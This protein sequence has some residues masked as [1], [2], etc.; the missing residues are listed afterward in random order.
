M[1]STGFLLVLALTYT[2]CQ[3]LP[4]NVVVIGGAA[5]QLYCSDVQPFRWYRYLPSNLNE[6]KVIYMGT[7]MAYDADDRF[8]V[9]A[10]PDRQ[11]YRRLDLLVSNV[12]SDLAGTYQCQGTGT[13]KTYCAE[14]IVLDSEPVCE[15]R[16]GRENTSNG[17]AELRCGFNMSSNGEAEMLC[18]R[19]SDGFRA[20][21]TTCLKN[22]T[23]S[24]SAAA[25]VCRATAASDWS[26]EDNFTCIIRI[27]HRP[28][29]R[30]KTCTH[31][32]NRPEFTY[33]WKYPPVRPIAADV[34]DNPAAMEL[35]VDEAVHCQYLQLMVEVGF[36]AAGAIILVLI[37]AVVCLAC[38]V[39]CGR[40]KGRY[41]KARKTSS[42][43]ETA[44]SAYTSLTFQE[45]EEIPATT[46]TPQAPRTS[47]GSAT[48]TATYLSANPQFVESPYEGMRRT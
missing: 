4:A 12:Q 44:P 28:L 38:K 23:D 26:E 1:S 32:S 34:R 27:N 25:V 15:F 39:R 6:D 24:G 13:G 35:V 17:T 9:F 2:Y 10:V 29:Q 42:P 33:I 18:E 46:T 41:E 37:V 40:D 20:E 5:V 36:P 16:D 31:A 21:T 11:S 22:S 3:D 14:L 19:N 30:Y 48:A 7:R 8:R 43:V 45:Y 47:A